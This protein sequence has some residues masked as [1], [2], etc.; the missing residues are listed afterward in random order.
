MS[1]DGKA[2]GAG[3]QGVSLDQ[4]DW[5]TTATAEQSAVIVEPG[6]GL[7][8]WGA[9]E[10]LV[11]KVNKDQ[12]RGAFVLAEVTVTPGGGPPPHKH[13][14]EDE[15][16]YILDGQMEFLIGDRIVPATR[17]TF[18]WAPRGIVHQFRAKGGPA[19]FLLVV[20]PGHLETMFMQFATPARPGESDAPPMDP[21]LPQRIV[22]LAARDY[23]IEF[24]FDADATEQA[25]LPAR[26]GLWVLGSHV[27]LL[28]DGKETNGQMC[29]IEVVAPPEAGP[30][31]HFHRDESETFYVV[32]GEFEMTV[33]DQTFAAAAGTTVHVPAGMVHAFRNCGRTRGRILSFHH[34]AGME[35]FY[36]ECGVDGPVDIQPP[37]VG[38][39]DP[40][41]II[42]ILHRHGMGLPGER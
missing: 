5:M 26:R 27:T 11:S 37:E 12:T 8:F 31:P 18:V 15:A 20:T 38:L 17:G 30:P 42:E 9:G 2:P 34:P 14:R 21:S 22:E 28:A 41:R 39:P 19:R 33:G 29:I 13:T 7:A 25:A 40:Q 24:A 23:G 32:D 3:A 10:R 4:G 6:A 1:F 36:E 35:H 16:F